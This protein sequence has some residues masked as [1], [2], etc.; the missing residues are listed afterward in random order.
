MWT[1]K[2]RCAGKNMRIMFGLVT[3]T[4]IMYKRTSGQKYK[5]CLRKGLTKY[6]FKMFQIDVYI[7]K[8]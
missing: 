6:R 1:K 2:K 3:M 8:P 5:Y 7:M 4:P